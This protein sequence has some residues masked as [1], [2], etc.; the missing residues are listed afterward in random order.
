MYWRRSR[1]ENRARE[2]ESPVPGADT[3]LAGLRRVVYFDTG[4]LSGR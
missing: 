1:T 4:A 2:G 3:Y